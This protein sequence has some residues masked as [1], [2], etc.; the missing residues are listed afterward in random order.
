[1]N[2]DVIRWIAIS[3][4]EWKSCEWMVKGPNK[5]NRRTRAGRAR[6]RRTRARKT[7]TRAR[8]RTLKIIWRRRK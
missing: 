2:E 6:A 5:K 4:E 7:K 1:M 3:M 8:T